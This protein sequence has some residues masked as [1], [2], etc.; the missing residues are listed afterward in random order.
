MIGPDYTGP[1][2]V[3][4][5]RERP[6]E[7]A[8]CLHGW[9]EAG[10]SSPGIVIVDG[11][12]HPDYW[13]LPVPPGWTLFRHNRRRGLSA[14]LRD[15]LEAFPLASSY[16]WLSDDNYPVTFE[17]DRRL[18]EAAGEW[19][20]SYAHDGGYLSDVNPHAPA[21]GRVLTA[22]LCWGGE[23]VR[24]VGWLAFPGSY[25]AGTDVAWTELVRPLCLHRYLHATIVEH[26]HWRAGK[27]LQD[28]LD[29]DE[30][31]V[32]GQAHT[33]EDCRRLWAWIGSEAHEETL[34]RV[35]AAVRDR[36]PAV[37][38]LRYPGPPGSL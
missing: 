28:E 8:A 5:T 20:L 7:A 29:T 13:N 18:E 4:V 34:G 1:V 26:R 15:L 30:E 17:F 14:G 24:T 23:L 35:E 37:A 38:R 2:W 36:A 11:D 31:D 9:Q 27:R 16:G 3:L 19:C 21:S 6:R 32:N 25:Q 22:G 10:G 12:E 33:I